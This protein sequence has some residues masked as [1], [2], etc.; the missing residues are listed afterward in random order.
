MSVF[1]GP[2]NEGEAAAE[3]L[4]DRV[5][6]TIVQQM[7]TVLPTLEGYELVIRVSLEKKA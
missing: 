6:S 7:A 2:I 1:S 3:K 4:T 5:S